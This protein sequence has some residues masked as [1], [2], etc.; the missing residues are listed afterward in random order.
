ML[1]LPPQKKG[2]ITACQYA[3]ARPSTLVQPPSPSSTSESVPAE[4]P[5]PA[6]DKLANLERI[7]LQL[8]S[9]QKRQHGCLDDQEESGSNITSAQHWTRQSVDEARLY[10]IQE[11]R[12][13]LRAQHE[14]YTQHEQPTLPLLPS[15]IE[16]APTLLLG[17]SRNATRAE[18]L[19]SLPSKETCDVL[20]SSQY[21]RFW[22]DPDSTTIVWVAIL[23][24]MMRIAS[25]DYLREED[26][27]LQFKGKCQSLAV[28]Y[29][30]R[31]ADCLAFADYLQPHEFLVEAL[32]L[33]QY[34]EYVSS[35]DAKSSIWVL[36]GTII[37]LAM[38]MGYHQSSQ[39]VLCQSPFKIGLPPMVDFSSSP[40]D[41]PSNIYD[42]DG[43]HEACTSIP[44]AQ[45]VSEPTKISY[46]I[47]KTKLAFGFAQAL[48]E[49]N[50]K[51]FVDYQRLLKIDRDLRRTYD[52]VPEYYKLGRLHSQ[53]SFVL[54][55]A[56][57]SLAAIHHKSLCVIHSHYIG[58]EARDRCH[59]YSTK[60]CLT[61][62]LAILRMQATQDQVLSIDGRLRKLTN[63]QTSLAIHDYLLAAAIISSYLF[64]SV[65]VRGNSAQRSPKAKTVSPGLPSNME[66]IKALENSA[67]IF[68][69]IREKS[70]DAWKA[71][72]V[73]GVISQR[74]LG[75]VRISPDI[76]KDASH[77]QQA[78]SLGHG[79]NGATRLSSDGDLLPQATMHPSS[80]AVFTDQFESEQCPEY[81]LSFASADNHSMQ[82]L[83][84]G[85]QYNEDNGIDQAAAVDYGDVMDDSPS[86]WLPDGFFPTLDINQPLSTLWSLND[87]GDDFGVLNNL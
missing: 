31:L 67:K 62:A 42:D 25:L 43:F 72:D 11:V 29:R 6:L 41:L 48:A 56:R 26:E 76:S 32:I 34:A 33:H 40:T 83:G 77:S 78:T 27:P 16:S 15:S 20:V 8:V 3:S 50:R 59:L 28:T 61:S 53:D 63:Y 64:S 55:S 17:S 85:E 22:H 80:E 44:P 1:A 79:E 10:Q 47:A 75:S 70:T 14:R 7:V 24:A 82:S 21:E 4:I 45:P 86:T 73:L 5:G 66:L 81:S 37:R 23:F 87:A 38:R 58:L 36:T 57:F 52:S 18:L 46:L 49:V 35:R 69:S 51:S 9:S 13:H 74:L 60:V 68:R 30:Q 65:G 39:P 84:L 12:C 71:A 54:C 19:L 2:N